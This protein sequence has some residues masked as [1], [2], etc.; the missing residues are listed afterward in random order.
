MGSGVSVAARLGELARDGVE[1]YAVLA[2]N[3]AA[4]SDNKIHDDEVAAAYGF[5]G[6]LVPGVAV[7]A[8]MSRPVVEALG[9]EWL[10]CGG[11]AAKF[12]QPV[13]D[14]DRV[15]A[16]A[17]VEGSGLKLELRD[18]AQQLCA[19]GEAYA[20]PGSATTQEPGAEPAGQEALADRYPV[21]PL[22]PHDAR[23][24][25]AVGSMPVGSAVGTLSV[26][27]E[28]RRSHS[29]AADR[30]RDTSALY[31]AA[32]S[33]LHPAFLADRAN[34]LLSANIALGPWIHTQSRMHFHRV[35]RPSDS[36]TLRGRYLAAY[37]KRGHHIVE[38]DLALFSEGEVAATIVHT[39]IVRPRQ[40]VTQS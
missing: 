11:M 27:D 12:L 18:S 8:Y 31:A 32:G 37:E 21:A 6:G 4:D 13:Y 23:L 3:F 22:P 24:P 36:M 26:A 20:G 1:P 10:G 29:V 5:R 14:G 9:E 15:T 2:H 35:L 7:L 34:S 17:A 16:S 40:R 39:S 33:P 30:Y 38:L 19:V 25:P 28:A